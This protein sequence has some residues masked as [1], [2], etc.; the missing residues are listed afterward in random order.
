M[1]YVAWIGAASIYVFIEQVG[2]ARADLN[3]RSNP[4]KQMVDIAAAELIQTQTVDAGPSFADASVECNV[5]LRKFIC[6]DGH[7][8]GGKAK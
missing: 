3:E 8:F 6:E 4:R 5:R 2:L 1:F 7:Q